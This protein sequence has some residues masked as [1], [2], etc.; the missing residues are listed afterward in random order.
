MDP[1]S[2]LCC[3]CD[4]NIYSKLQI[5]ERILPC[6]HILCNSCLEKSL[7]TSKSCVVC[8]EEHRKSSVQNTTNVV[9]ELLLGV[10]QSV[11][12]VNSPKSNLR[13]SKKEVLSDLDYNIKREINN[14][15][16]LVDYTNS[17]ALREFSSICSICNSAKLYRC[18]VCEVW[19]C[20]YCDLLLPKVDKFQFF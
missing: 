5:D 20:N 8:E 7:E 4:R 9:N 14:Q 10:A 2:C 13:V 3:H 12:T 1:P 19:V 16:S 17:L 15:V 6:G 11:L 18:V